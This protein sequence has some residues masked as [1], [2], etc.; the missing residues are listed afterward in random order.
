V[1]HLQGTAYKYTV[2]RQDPKLIATPR[3]KFPPP[4]PPYHTSPFSPQP[5]SPQ[6]SHEALSA[7]RG[8]SPTAT[9]PRFSHPSPQ[10]QF[11]FR[12][13]HDSTSYN[14]RGPRTSPPNN[15]CGSESSHE[16][17]RPPRHN[18]PPAQ[19][20]PHNHCSHG[21][22]SS[23]CGAR[24]AESVKHVRASVPSQSPTTVSRP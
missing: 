24:V 3:Q 7:Q 2:A 10:P 17:P 9:R 5:R 20:Q 23:H 8:H 4:S 14:K 6:C 11:P 13:A 21:T 18:Q 16:Q 15:P 1:S 12:H 22:T 19:R